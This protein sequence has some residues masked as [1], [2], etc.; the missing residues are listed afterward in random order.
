[1]KMTLNEILIRY[2]SIVKLSEKKLPIKLSY[3]LLKNIFKLRN[4][5]EIIDN[6]RIKLA[7]IYAEKNDD[8]SPKTKDGNFIIENEEQFHKEFDDYCQ[9]EIEVDICKCKRSEFDKLEEPRYDALSPSEILSLEFMI[10]D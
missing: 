1:M 4:E 8:G 10:E 9:T 6:N 3:A 2:S 5:S 7:E